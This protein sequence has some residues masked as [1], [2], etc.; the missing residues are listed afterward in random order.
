MALE[1]TG[2]FRYPKPRA[3][4]LARHAEAIIDPDRPIVDAHHHLWDEPGNQYFTDHLLAD[5][6]T[7]HRI[8]ATVAVQAHY[9]YRSTGP[10]HLKPVGETEQLE[11]H[12]R[13][14]RERGAGQRPCA[15]IVGFADLRD[16]DRL[17][18]VLDAHAAASP[19][20][21]RGVRQSV[22]RDRHFPEGVVLRPSPAGMLADPV[23][24]KS[25]RRL[26]A[27][28]LVFDAMLYHEQIPELT[29]LADE[30]TE[31]PIVL[32]HCGCPLGV[33]YYTGRK[34]ERF[35]AWRRDVTELAR[36][37]NV[38]VKIGG[39]GMIITGAEYHL[40]E[41][42]PTSAQLAADWRPW[43]E[44]CIEAFGALRCM[45]ESNFPVDK[46]MYSYAVCWNAFKRLAA[47]C[48]ATEQDELFA[49]TASRVY[50]LET[51]AGPG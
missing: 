20:H 27:R 47:G 34:P 51:D 2:Q 23:F 36:R 39:L 7:G 38:C 25:T 3:E 8:V 29:A 6:R 43:F 17:D 5:L 37:P 32:D 9:G 45:F 48:S 13:E 10:E 50:R 1:V 21:F 12:R 26:G 15:A 31:T 28:G 18:E 41:R 19:G 35:E 46:A 22:A 14:G 16:G 40:A 24:R 4:W 49:N 30:V 33:G 11:R 44:A 42:P